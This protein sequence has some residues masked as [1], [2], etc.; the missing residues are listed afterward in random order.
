MHNYI[1]KVTKIINV[2]TISLRGYQ[3]SGKK[4]IA[5]LIMLLYVYKIYYICVLQRWLLMLNYKINIILC[6]LQCDG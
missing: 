5:T 2:Y 4:R 6:S 1:E 3:L